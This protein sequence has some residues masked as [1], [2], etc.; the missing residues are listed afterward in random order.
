MGLHHNFKLA[1]RLID[2]ISAVLTLLPGLQSRLRGLITIFRT[3][4]L[5][6]TDMAPGSC[7][8][9]TIG[10]SLTEIPTEATACHCLE[11]RKVFSA[12][13]GPWF[14][15]SNAVLT[16]TVKP[17]LVEKSDIAE[18]GYCSNC[19][20][21]TTMVYFAQPQRTYLSAVGMGLR[22]SEHIFLGEQEEGYVIPDDGAPRYQEFNPPFEKI[23]QAWRKSSG[24]NKGN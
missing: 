7:K 24:S 14:G 15:V 8:C 1:A 9:G 6:G 23:L 19:H 16:W 21:P 17:D 4:E 22:I 13:Y 10:Y 18:R 12:A 11:C 3:G 20:T 2:S 5:S